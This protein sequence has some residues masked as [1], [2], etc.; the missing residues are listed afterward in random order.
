MTRKRSRGYLEM[1]GTLHHRKHVSTLGVKRD[2]CSRSDDEKEAEHPRNDE[3]AE[4]QP[5]Q[6]VGE[7][8]VPR[9][10]VEIPRCVAH[11]GSELYFAKLP[12]F[13]SVET[14]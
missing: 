12:N 9:I 5:P 11:L 14:K 1:Q 10:N 7:E 8:Q 13:L 4:P 2:D 3:G 6:D